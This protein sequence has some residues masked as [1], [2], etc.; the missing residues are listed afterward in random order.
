MVAVAVVAALALLGA[1]CSSGKAGLKVGLAYG[2]GGPGDHGFNDSALA[3]LN[4]AQKQLSG[5]VSTVKALT[6]RANE[7][8]E[9]QFQRL[10]LLCEAGYNPVIAVGY[11][12]AGPNPT[13]GPL[14]RAAKDCPQ[15]HFAIV[16]DDTVH[17]RNVANL[18]FADQ[19]GSFLVGVVAASKSTTGVVGLVGAC[20]IP[21]INRFLAGYQA[22]AKAVRPDITVKVGYV[23]NDPARCD[24]TDVADARSV[25]AGLYVNR[26]DVVFQ[27]AGGSGIGVFQAAVAANGKAIGVD[28]DQYET[29]SASLRP[30]ILTSM[31]KR[32]DNAVFDFIKRDSTGTFTP[33]IRRYN[34]ADNGLGYATSGGQ[35]TGLVPALEA[36]RQ[37]IISGEIVVPVTP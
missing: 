7:T 10:S 27:V 9:D 25:A 29:V 35:I 11:T 4:R 5:S 15:T 36:Y 24:F 37:K 18:V 17:E 8:Q 16:D 2:V 6:A 34:L 20:D 23:S 30:V 32:V 21:L 26:A 12:Y 14:A 33:G 3:G 31:V 13:N 19:Q 22:G 28:E 1:A